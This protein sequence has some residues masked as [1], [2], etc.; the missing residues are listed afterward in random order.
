VSP[1][2]IKPFGVFVLIVGAG[3][4]LAALWPKLVGQVA[5]PET[6]IITTLKRAERDGLT[7]PLR[8]G[9]ALV[10]KQLTFDRIVVQ[11]DGKADRAR[12]VSTLDFVGTAGEIEV[13]S[14]GLEHTPF[15]RGLSGWEAPDGFA[16]RLTAAVEALRSRVAAI[17]SGDRALLS[18]LSVPEDRQRLAASEDLT[19]L[20]S[21][22]NRRYQP[23]TW[24]LRSERDGLTVTEKYRLEG[25]LPNR[26][27]DEVGER[28]LNL[29]WR[30]GRLLFQGG[31]L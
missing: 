27:V 29:V 22:T 8:S 12:A 17:D 15:Q 4:A 7:V 3:I 11:L 16:P 2:F 9:G 20:L 5:N 31:V 13:S 14:L 19:Q 6:E 26:P 21:M 1:G 30:D 10:A 24:Y 28:R 18:A 23:R 25:D